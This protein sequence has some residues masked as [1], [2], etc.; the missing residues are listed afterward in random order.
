MELQV[1][2][3][4]IKDRIRRGVPDSELNKPAGEKNLKIDAGV[5]LKIWRHLQWLG[6][7][8]K[9]KASISTATAE[10]FGVSRSI[11]DNI[12]YGNTWNKV[13]GMPRRNYKKQMEP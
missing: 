2:I 13:T 12:R 3:S 9:S 10:K 6:K 7:N 8:S 1:S 4:T 11:V 5:A